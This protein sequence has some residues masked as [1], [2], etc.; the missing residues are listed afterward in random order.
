MW[1]QDSLKH[2]TVRPGEWYGP[3]ILMTYGEWYGPIMLRIYAWEAGRFSLCG[4]FV[5]DWHP[6]PC[7]CRICSLA[8]PW[9]RGLSIFCGSWFFVLAP[10][11]PQR[12]EHCRVSAQL[13]QLSTTLFLLLPLL[14]VSLKLVCRQAKESFHSPPGSNSHQI[15]PSKDP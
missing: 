5:S 8:M 6:S 4:W 15:E 14:G 11:A 10:S 2:W 13:T 7:S 1:C 12:W 9:L 3:I